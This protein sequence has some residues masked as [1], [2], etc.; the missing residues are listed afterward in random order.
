[1]GYNQATQEVM[2]VTKDRKSQRYIMCIY[3]Y[4]ICY[5]KYICIYNMLYCCSLKQTKQL[6]K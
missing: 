2:R 3:V 1:M 6:N 4:I 5:V